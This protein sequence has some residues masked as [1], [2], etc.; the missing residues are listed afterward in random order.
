DTE[1]DPRYVESEDR[2]IRSI[3]SVPINTY[4]KLRCVI[5]ADSPEPNHFK[6]DDIILFSSLGEHVSTM[7]ESLRLREV[8]LS[9]S[10][11]PLDKLHTEVVDSAFTLV[12]G[13]IA[14]LSVVQPD[15]SIKIVA[16]YPADLDL[17]PP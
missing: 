15:G 7:I 1:N 3:L 17:E 9:L 2:L 8:V 13:D 5:N 11:L 4:E 14:T 16:T 6:D 12:R 10:S